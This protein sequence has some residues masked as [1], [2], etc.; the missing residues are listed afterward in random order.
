MV[1]LGGKAGDEIFGRCA[2]CGGRI[3]YGEKYFRLSERIICSGCC[4]EAEAEGESDD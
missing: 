2:E 4:Y 3:F 1:R